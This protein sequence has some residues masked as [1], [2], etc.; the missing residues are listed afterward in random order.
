MKNIK[1]LIEINLANETRAI[2][3]K[4]KR[5]CF[6]HKFV[7]DQVYKHILDLSLNK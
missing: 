1:K 7:S 4:F 3:E 6:S 2:D 5:F